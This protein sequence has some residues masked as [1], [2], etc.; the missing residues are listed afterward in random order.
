MRRLAR[1]LRGQGREAHAVT[2]QPSWGEAGIDELAGKLATL[3]DAEAGPGTPIDLIG[4]SMGGLIC[5][6]YVQRLGGVDRVKCL[7][8]IASPH[9]GTLNAYWF[10]RPACRQMRPGSDFL[11]DLNADL[12]ALERVH[13]LSLWTPFDLIILPANSSRMSVGKES[14]HL[15]VAHPLMVWQRSVWRAIHGG[16]LAGEG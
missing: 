3:I 9:R 5:R 7:F 1:F 8:T 2:L 15:I 4:F 13:F 10:D 6:Y 11:R 16:L 12:T 14:R